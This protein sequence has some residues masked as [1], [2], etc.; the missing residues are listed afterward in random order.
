MDRARS[1]NGAS[2]IYLAVVLGLLVW[3]IVDS[4]LVEHQDASFAGVWPVLATLPT[5][6]VITAMPEA[7]AVVLV[8]CIAI[9][10]LLNAFLLGRVVHALR[11][12]TSRA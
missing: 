10:G 12:D 2:R 11:K 5:S 1:N 3:V 8:L 6:L 7:P 9:A 4:T